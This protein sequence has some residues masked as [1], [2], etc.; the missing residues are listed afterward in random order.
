MPQDKKNLQSKTASNSQTDNNDKSPQDF[1]SDNKYLRWIV[2]PQSKL[3]RIVL[4]VYLKLPDNLRY[5][6]IRKTTDV[7][8]EI[9][10]KAKDHGGNDMQKRKEKQH[11]LL[12]E[13]LKDRERSI[14]SKFHFRIYSVGTQDPTDGVAESTRFFL[15]RIHHKVSIEF[16]PQN[17]TIRNQIASTPGLDKDLAPYL[18]SGNFEDLQN[19]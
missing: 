15:P 5:E 11:D 16:I 1:T 12:K 7:Y 17:D 6:F 19:N 8:A 14:E 13:F 18:S 3:N 10:H 9:N 2:I 4:K